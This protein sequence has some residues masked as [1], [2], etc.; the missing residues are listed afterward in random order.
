MFINNESQLEEVLATPTLADSESLGRLGGDVVIL[1]AGGKIGPS[2]SRRVKRAVETAGLKSRVIAV[3]RFTSGGTAQELRAAGVEVIECDLLDHKS[4]SRLPDAPNVLFL[5]GRKFGSTERSDVTWAM[6]TMVPA[7]AAER[8][9]SSRIVV[10]STGNIYPPVPASTGGCAET[11][12]TAPVGEYAQS[13]LG[14]ERIFEYFS[15]ELRTRCL[16]FR[17]NYAV[18]LRYGVL[19]DIARK[20]R[21]G[22]PVEAGVACF[23]VVWQGDVNS[24]AIRSLELC[25]S[26]PG[27]LNV[28]GPEILSVRKTAEYFGRRF[29]REPVFVG[30]ESG[31]ALLSDASECHT[32]LGYPEV[33]VG[34]LVVWVADW[35]EQG[36]RLLNKPTHFEVADGKY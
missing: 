35:L 25:S 30:E 4:Y 26:P 24:Y 18:D 3:S 15:R 8:Y 7:Y 14:R 21:D 29:G 6:N 34:Q 10:F 11:D 17:L 9:S 32:L 5:A 22:E 2:L 23:N 12:A 13:C 36:G 16:F 1:G 19:V 31:V 27:I 33:P 28:T 20:V